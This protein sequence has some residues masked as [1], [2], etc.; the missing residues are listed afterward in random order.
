MGMA[1]SYGKNANSP[2]HEGHLGLWVE[3]QQLCSKAEKV[4]RRPFPGVPFWVS[5]QSISLQ[6]QSF[7]FPFSLRLHDPF[8]C[9]SEVC[10]LN[11]HSPFPQRQKSGLAADGFDV[12]STKIVLLSDEFIQVDILGQRHFAGMQ[13][14]N[15]FL[16][17]CVRILE[18][19]FP[20][21]TPGSDESRVQSV[22]LVCCHN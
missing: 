10:H 21:N 2:H 3:V 7:W 11:P 1:D 18:Q 9:T 6:I 17:V 14:E 13:S 12:G 16:R 8:S 4:N 19:D 20:V 22:D 5:Q 15:L